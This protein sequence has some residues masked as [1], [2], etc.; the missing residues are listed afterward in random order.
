MPDGPLTIVVSGGV[1][2]TVQAYVAGVGSTLPAASTARTASVWL[3]WPSP[4]YV[5]GSVHATNGPPSRL[6][7]YVTGL[8]F[9]EKSNVAVV[10]F[11]AAGGPLTIVVSG[12]VPSTVHVRDAGVGSTLPAASTARTSKVCEPSARPVKVTGSVHGT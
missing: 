12:G 6:H 10:E 1:V 3:P 5:T 4:V 7:S 9:E 11:V 2:S 8:S